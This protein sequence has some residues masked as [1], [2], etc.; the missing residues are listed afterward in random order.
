M[1][2]CADVYTLTGDPSELLFYKNTLYSSFHFSDTL[3]R[4]LNE[5]REV[6][7]NLQQKLNGVYVCC[8][9]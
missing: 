8:F 1:S 2:A 9:N 6:R 4:K 7:Q 3:F 5:E